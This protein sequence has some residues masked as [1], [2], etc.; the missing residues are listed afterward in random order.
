MG[1]CLGQGRLG[2][3]SAYFL[4]IVYITRR[5]EGLADFDFLVFGVSGFGTWVGDGEWE[6]NG[7]IGRRD[8]RSGKRRWGMGFVSW[9]LC[10]YEKT[11]DS[12]GFFFSF[13]F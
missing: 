9:L 10:V 13:L 12:A 2:E 7:G 8:S 11:G 4:C 6:T 5:I 1:A 3:L